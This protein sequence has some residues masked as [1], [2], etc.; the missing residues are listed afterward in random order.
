MHAT[1][2]VL[3]ARRAPPQNASELR[4]LD[5][6]ALQALT[7]TRTLTRTLT[8][9]RTRTRTLTLTLTPTLQALRPHND[10][11]A[12][13]SADVLMAQPLAHA[14]LAITATNLTMSHVTVLDL[15]FSCDKY[16]Y[17]QAG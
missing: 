16:T 11:I 8:R 12:P 4:A 2:L 10:F 3:A 14:S 17:P 15:G 1:H 13:E 5:T 6:A 9:T 7:R